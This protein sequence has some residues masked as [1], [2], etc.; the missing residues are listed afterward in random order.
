MLQA[1]V[2]PLLGISLM[3]SVFGQ[4][5]WS[6]PLSDGL[7]QAPVYLCQFGTTVSLYS[8]RQEADGH[9]EGLGPLEGWNVMV[10]EDG[11]VARNSDQLLVIGEGPDSLVQG[12]EVVQGECADAQSA[13][14]Q[15]F[16]NDAAGGG[17]GIL[18]GGEPDAFATDLSIREQEALLAGSLPANS[19]LWVA[20]ILSIFNSGAWDADKVAAIVDALSLE[21]SLKMS[22]KAELKAAGR[23]PARVASLARQIQRVIVLQAVATAEVRTKLQD[24]RLELAV[25]TRALEVQRQ[26]AEE[27]SRLLAAAKAKASAAERANNQTAAL[28]KAAQRALREKD[29]ALGRSAQ[30]MAALRQ[31]SSGL[32]EHLRVL[33]AALDA[34][35]AEQ[36]GTN[37]EVA[38][39]IQQ[40]T[41]T[42]ARLARAEKKIEELRGVRK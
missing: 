37:L 30:D 6:D 7:T 19:D 41:E 25:V 28:L 42:R 3:T 23:D 26:R 11:L 18:G 32:H 16:G 35:M 5:A 17:S 20:G 10:Q 24:S 33:Q 39:L 9:L 36:Q 4:A 13:L 22:L 31:Q 2:W 38:A 34:A 15:L 1:R 21:R 12:G 14:P 27:S 29:A 40:L 8:F